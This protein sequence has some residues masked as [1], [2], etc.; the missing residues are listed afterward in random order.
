MIFLITFQAAT[1]TLGAV[2]GPLVGLFFL[3]VFFPRANK[4]G[5]YAG[6][7]VALVF[8]CTCSISYNIQK[9]YKNYILPLEQNVNNPNCRAFNANASYHQNYHISV[10]KDEHNPHPVEIHTDWH[11]GDPDT[12]A[13]SRISPFAYAAI[14]VTTVVV[15]GYIV[16]LIFPVELDSKKE[17]FAYACTYSGLDLEVDKSTYRLIEM[18]DINYDKEFN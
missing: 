16:S 8:I 3:G 11:Y 15:V 1:T 2:S 7:G 4:I 6:L 13:L 12:Y 18:K 5:A 10:L 14:G 17:K 9:P